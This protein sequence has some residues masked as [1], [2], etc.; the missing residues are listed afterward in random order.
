MIKEVAAYEK[1]VTDNTAKLQKMESGGADVY[2]IKK[3]KEVLAESVMMVP[4]SKTRLSKSVEDLQLFV[5]SAAEQAGVKDSE[6]WSKASE[7]IASQGSKENTAVT[8]TDTTDLAE[9][10][11]F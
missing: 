7:V 5:D 9:G 11:A 4:D 8:T 2:D 10:E 6:W 1:E 3:F